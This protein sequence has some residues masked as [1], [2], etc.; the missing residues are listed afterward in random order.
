MNLVVAKGFKEMSM[1][2]SKVRSCVR[3]LTQSPA[4]VAKFIECA[5]AEKM[6]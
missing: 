3:F 4:R 6:V 1:S 2:F 5:L